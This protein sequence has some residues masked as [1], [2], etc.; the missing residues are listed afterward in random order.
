MKRI[1]ASNTYDM[2]DM[3]VFFDYLFFS[4]VKVGD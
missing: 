2:I 1:Y 4:A 3:N